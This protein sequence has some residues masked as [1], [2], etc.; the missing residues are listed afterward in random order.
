[1]T[2]QLF[3]EVVLAID[4]LAKGLQKGDVATIIEEHPVVDGEEG[5]TLEVFNTLDDTIAVVTV[6]ESAIVSMTAGEV[7]SVRSYFVSL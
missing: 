1:M 5:H 3:Q 4:V 7:L 2:D 6:P